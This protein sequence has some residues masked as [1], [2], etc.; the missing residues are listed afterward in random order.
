[1]TSPALTWSPTPTGRFTTL[2]ATRK[3]IGGGARRDHADEIAGDRIV[4]IGDA[5]DLDRPRGRS[6]GAVSAWQAASG[7][8]GEHHE[9]GIAGSGHA[10]RM[11]HMKL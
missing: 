3:A 5:R 7:E 6:S 4:G 8:R 10:L 1:M 2:P 11:M 9:D